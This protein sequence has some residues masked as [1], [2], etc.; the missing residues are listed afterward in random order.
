MMT[1]LPALVGALYL[2]IAQGLMGAF[3]TLYHHEFT[4][5]LPHSPRAQ[6]ELAIHALRAVLYGVLFGSVANLQFFGAWVFAIAILVLVE[7]GLTLW[8]FVVEDQSRKLPAS[9]RVLHTLLAINGGALFG[10]YAMQL[11]EWSH[12]PTGL[13]AAN[14]GWQGRV[15]SVFAVGV[16]ASGVRDGVAAYRMARSRPQ[17]NPFAGQRHQHVLVTGGT[18]F[19]GEALVTQVTPSPCWHATRCARPTSFRAGC[20][21]SRPWRN[22]TL[23]NMSIR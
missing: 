9:E 12:A 10:L 16:A 5:D 2:L 8:D 23:R 6:R 13:A 14:F 3:D 22:S 17:E 19:I 20:A 11:L 21:V 15:L 1:T 7:V 18:G 4:Q